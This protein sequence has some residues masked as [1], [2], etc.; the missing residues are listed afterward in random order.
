MQPEL[1][2]NRIPVDD[3]DL[4]L[5]PHADRRCDLGSQ[6]DERTRNRLHRKSV[7]VAAHGGVAI[8]A[9]VPVQAEA[10]H[11][12]PHLPAASDGRP[13]ETR[14]RRAQ[15]EHALDQ[16]ALRLR[17]QV[18]GQVKD[19]GHDLDL[20]HNDGR[21]FAGRKSSAEYL[22]PVRRYIPEDEATAVQRQL[23]FPRVLL[24]ALSVAA[25]NPPAHAAA[26]AFDHQYR[27][28]SGVLDESL[29]GSRVDYG[30]LASDRVALDAAVD[31]LSAVPRE[32]FDA[33]SRAQ[34][35]AYWINAYNVL[36]L[37]VIVDHYP[38]RGSWLSLYPRSSIRQIDGVW[39]DITWHAGGRQVTLDEIEHDILRPTFAEPL[40]HFAINCAALS[41]P[42]LRGEPF[43]AERL[44]AQ[45]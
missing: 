8:G 10:H 22:G 1:A 43:V 38:I 12:D 26:Q 42:P 37:R 27:T 4:R 18:S 19:A 29:I 6:R 20:R 41:C 2:R 24:V 9:G 32:T 40:V 28:Y 30:R 34:R 23:L 11:V 5:D 3:T 25:A 15:G 35:L 14:G 21:G 16:F 7:V 44:E 13:V 39:D 33:W 17:R 36:T 45:L 31:E